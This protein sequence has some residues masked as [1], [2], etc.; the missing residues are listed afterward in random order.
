MNGLKNKGIQDILIAC[1]DGLTGFTQAIEA[2][3]PKT[4]IQHCII[5]SRDLTV[6][7]AR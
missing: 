2:V 3:Y 7:F 4:E 1:I 5:P 6:N